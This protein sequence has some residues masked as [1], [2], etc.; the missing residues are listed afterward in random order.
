M[1]SRSA[2]RRRMRTQ[3]EWKVETHIARARG[4]DRDL[5]PLAHLGGG[6]VRERDGQDLAGSGVAGGQQVGDPAGEHPGLARPG[7]GDDQQR[8]A[9]VLD[10]L[11]LRRVEV[12]DEVHHLSGPRR[13]PLGPAVRCLGVG[14]ALGRGDRSAHH[15][16]GTAGLSR[17][18]VTWRRAGDA[19]AAGM[20][21]GAAVGA[22]R[23]QG[24]VV[25]R[26]S[27]SR[28]TESLGRVVRG[29]RGSRSSASTCGF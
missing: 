23:E 5:D 29:R 1:P 21:M 18:R 27:A 26:G 20:R 22:G 15:V 14:A 12:G 2:S 7:A 17:P 10:G 25:G 11:A 8:A 9:A 6:L 28:S 3:A 16:G 4:P 19:A 13:L 24:A